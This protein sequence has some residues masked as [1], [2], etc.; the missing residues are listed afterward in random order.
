MLTDMTYETEDERKARTANS[1]DQF[2][3]GWGDDPRSVEEIK[4]DIRNSRTTNSFF[5]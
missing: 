4:S 5:A 2:F 1:I 3:G